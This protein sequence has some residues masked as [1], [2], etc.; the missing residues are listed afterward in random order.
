MHKDECL[1]TEKHI[2]FLNEYFQ[3]YEK[4]YQMEEFLG[5]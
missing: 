2:M 3:E 5:K 1:S 4:E